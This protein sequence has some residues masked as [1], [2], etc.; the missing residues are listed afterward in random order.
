MNIHSDN[1]EKFIMSKSNKMRYF[2]CYKASKSQL[3]KLIGAQFLTNM[4]LLHPE[5]LKISRF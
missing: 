2:L 1:I 5:I 3:L 4:E